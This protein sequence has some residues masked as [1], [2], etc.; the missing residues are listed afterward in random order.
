MK[1][2]RKSNCKTCKNQ[3]KDIAESFLDIEVIASL[4]KLWKSF[5]VLVTQ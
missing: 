3:Q 1:E 4:L 2:D 5:V